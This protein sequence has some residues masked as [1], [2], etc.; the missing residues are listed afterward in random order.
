[1]SAFI[2][3][4]IAIF[5][6]AFW[7][8]PLTHPSRPAYVPL[9]SPTEPRFPHHRP[10]RNLA[11]YSGGGVNATKNPCFRYK[12]LP[13]FPPSLP[14]RREVD[15]VGGALAI[16]A[17]VV[18]EP[19]AAARGGGQRERAQ[20]PQRWTFMKTTEL[21]ARGHDDSCGIN[22]PAADLD[23]GAP[24]GALSYPS[25]SSP[26]LSSVLRTPFSPLPP[27]TLS[28]SFSLSFP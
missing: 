16:D 8:S 23:V 28:P 4:A 6:T 21:A 5:C 11:S 9:R 27:S 2:S 17:L 19:A 10:A 15:D 7:S 24:D 12:E 20:E 13:S 3:I 25:G 1:M 18:V 22:I 14:L 26:S